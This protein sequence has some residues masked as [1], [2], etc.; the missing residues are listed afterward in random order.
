MKYK[1]SHSPETKSVLNV[2]VG[3]RKIILDNNKNIFSSF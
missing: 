2:S 3:N 1:F